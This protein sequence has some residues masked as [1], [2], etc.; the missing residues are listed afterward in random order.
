MEYFSA[1]I[2]HLRISLNR[3]F[4]LVASAKYPDIIDSQCSPP[5]LQLLWGSWVSILAT[6]VR[7]VQFLLPCFS[8]ILDPVDFCINPLKYRGPK[9]GRFL[10]IVTGRLIPKGAITRFRLIETMK[11]N[12]PGLRNNRPHLILSHICETLI[13]P[14]RKSSVANPRAAGSWWMCSLQNALPLRLHRG[15]TGF[16][17]ASWFWRYRSADVALWSYDGFYVPFTTA[18]GLARYT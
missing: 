17:L 2:R 13:S 8:G 3:Y 15:A 12:P 5:R 7:K 6:D 16:L 14:P 11:Y 10:G 9:L 18:R 1:S 4:P